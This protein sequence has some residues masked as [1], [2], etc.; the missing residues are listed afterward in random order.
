MWRR[1]CVCVYVKVSELDRCWSV[2]GLI[3]RIRMA[4]EFDAISGW[5]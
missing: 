2:R 5:E 1:Q 4:M 3:Y